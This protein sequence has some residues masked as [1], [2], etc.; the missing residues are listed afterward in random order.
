[1][2]NSR[3]QYG[4]SSTLDENEYVRN[5][6]VTLDLG[7]GH[8]NFYKDGTFSVWGNTATISFDEVSKEFSMSIPANSAK[9]SGL[10]YT[11]KNAIL[12]SGKT[13]TISYEVFSN[14]PVT[15]AFKRQNQ[16]VGQNYGT[17]NQDGSQDD[18]VTFATIPANEWTPV[19]FTYKNN[20][21]NSIYDYSV[22]SVE[23]ASGVNNLTIRN[24]K[25]EI[26]NANTKEDGQKETVNVSSTFL[27]WRY[28][29][30]GRTFGDKAEVPTNL[31][32]RSGS[33]LNMV[34]Q[35]KNYSFNLPEIYADGYE[36]KGW[37]DEDGNPV[38]PDKPVDIEEDKTFTAKWEDNKPPIVD[39]TVVN[40][41]TSTITTR[42]TVVDEGEGVGDNPYIYYIKEYGAPDR[43]YQRVEG[44]NSSEFIF[45]GLKPKTRYSIKVEIADKVGNVGEDSTDGTTLQLTGNIYVK[46]HYWIQNSNREGT[47]TVV[48]GAN[49]LSSNKI[50]IESRREDI[51]QYSK[52]DTVIGV[53]HGQTAFARLT[54]GVNNLDATSYTPI[55]NKSPT[56]EIRPNTTGENA[57]NN[58]YI[59]ISADDKESGLGL[60]PTYTYYYKRAQDTN[61]ITAGSTTS[62]SFN[63][64]NLQQ[65][66]I[67][68]IRVTVKDRAG[69]I[70]EKIIQVQTSFKYRIIFDG[71][72]A[73]SGNMDPLPCTKDVQATLTKN[74]YA[75]RGYSF[76]GW[77][78][79]IRNTPFKDGQKVINLSKHGEDVTLKAYWVDDI[80]PI[81][82]SAVANYTDIDIVAT[83][84]GS[85]V[86]GY[87][88]TTTPTIPGVFTPCQV[89][90]VL[91]TKISGLNMNT[92]YY[93]WV[94]DAAGN[95]SDYWQVKTLLRQYVVQFN[96]NG[97]YGS[98]PPT[99]YKTHGVDLVMDLKNEPKRDGWSFLGWAR[100][101][102]AKKREFEYYDLN[103]YPSLKVYCTYKENADITLYAVWYR[104][105]L[106]DL[107][108]TNNVVNLRDYEGLEEALELS[109]SPAMYEFQ[110]FETVYASNGRSDFP[111][112]STLLTKM[113]RNFLL[114]DDYTDGILTY[115][116]KE[117]VSILSQI[118]SLWYD[119]NITNTTTIEKNIP[120]K[121][122][123]ML[124]EY[125]DN[126]KNAKNK[127]KVNGIGIGQELEESINNVPLDLTNSW[128]AAFG[129]YDYRTLTED[130]ILPLY[131]KISYT[132]EGAG[133]NITGEH[134][135]PSRNDRLGGITNK[136]T[137]NM[138]YNYNL[139]K[140]YNRNNGQLYIKNWFEADG[141]SYA[142]DLGA[143]NQIWFSLYISVSLRFPQDI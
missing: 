13:A 126:Y 107:Q 142:G 132:A 5:Y 22:L 18:V 37:I 47:E 130:K 78:S 7:I 21:I 71:N 52:T 32:T 11:G 30:D 122:Y 42:T 15:L 3:H 69:N 114:N 67:Y 110:P 58:I 98:L 31:T 35:W 38:D 46:S 93:V 113:K 105:I 53:E 94:R 136:V 117:T 27:H 115:T 25:F 134:V 50:Y 83:D 128:L 131:S 133:N 2:Q 61:W 108:T 20:N 104:T 55:D 24:P 127:K 39:I 87:A 91:S 10:Y 92:V 64:S 116:C 68:D 14:K 76:Y 141:V 36:F 73:T 118:A 4:V 60:T 90:N 49:N 79:D 84:E 70:G 123:L 135:D 59:A 63:Y 80:K 109:Y 17:N 29:G 106:V 9:Y 95:I 40:T 82:T 111:Y 45:T 56:I 139:I 102:N 138:Q 125:N 23:D 26:I 72:G 33:I 143:G 86:A 51:A 97:G 16:V 137:T 66:T 89:T 41:T 57:M 81:I 62:E 75:R 101:P 12:K 140:S 119:S 48:F 121:V 19:Y 112:G 8:T 100:M 124:S 96:A 44:G 43:E 88:V 54:D 129:G 85:G 103:E 77:L 6:S 65:D 120:C 74:T 28:E 1:M 34:A 99:Q